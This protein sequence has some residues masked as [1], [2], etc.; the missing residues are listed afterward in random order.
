MKKLIDLMS[1]FGAEFYPKN[2]F[3]FPL[4]ISSSNY[5][6]GISYNSGTSAQ[7]KSAVILA[8]LNSYGN[9][10]IIEKLKSRNHTE[11]MLE[12]NKNA[13]KVNNGKIKKIEVFGKQNLKNFSINIPGDPS[14][15]AFFTALTLLKNNSTLKI[16]NVG[17]NPSRIGFYNLLKKAVLK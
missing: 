12:K 1:Q 13:I 11:N 16:K 4:T 9:T 6:I 10:H 3:F 5:P 8:G 2:K 7:L 15:A 17:L 14:S